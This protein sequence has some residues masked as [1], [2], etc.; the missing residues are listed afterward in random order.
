MKVALLAIS[1]GCPSGIGPEVLVVAAARSRERILI[2]GD[3]GVVGRAAELRRVDPKRFV[4]VASPREADLLGRGQVGVFEPTGP[5]ARRDVR[6]GAPSRAGG[7]AQLAWI[8][9]ACDLARRGQARAMVTGPVSKEAIV[10][11]GVRGA[12]GFIGHTEHLQR[13]LGAREVVMAFF[14]EKL[15]IALVT[16]HIALRDVATTLTRSRV[17]STVFWLSK[18]LVAVRS[19][20]RRPPRIA[21]AALNPHA[22]EH[23]LFGDEEP[24]ILSPGIALAEKRLQKHGVAV[25]LTGPVPAETVFRLATERYEGVVALYHDQATIPM[26]ILGFG[27]AVNVSLGLPIVRTSVDH[28]TAYDVAGR[29]VADARGMG[30]AIDLAA[31]LSSRQREG[32]AH[33]R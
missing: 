23:G 12:Q 26:K 17:A 25:T 18:L 32:R 22:G 11:S 33:G 9:A 2:V 24:R 30:A 1:L 31:R 13:R 5:L 6:Y 27:E 8:D 29:G 16:T 4:R 21:V 19:R 20:G 10:R 28:G 7:A 15:S 14:T 3:F